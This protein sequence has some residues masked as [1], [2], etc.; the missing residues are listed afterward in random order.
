[1]VKKILFPLVVAVI[2]FSIGFSVVYAK[3]IPGVDRPFDPPDYY[4]PTAISYPDSKPSAFTLKDIAGSG[5]NVIDVTRKIKSALFGGDF[6]NLLNIFKGKLSIDELN[7]TPFDGS[8]LNRTLDN[9][10]NTNAKTA[11]L[12][13][14]IDINN[15]N[16][17][18]PNENYDADKTYDSDAQSSWLSNIYMTVTQAAKENLNDAE[19]QFSTLEDIVNNS[20]NAQGELQVQQVSSELKSLNSALMAR[21]NALLSNNVNMNAAV[22]K[23]QVDEELEGIRNTDNMGVYFADP[24]NEKQYEAAD[25]KRPEAPGFKD[26][27]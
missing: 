23:Q 16:F 24:Y 10:E 5:G 15:G 21:R 6:L 2:G 26:F 8:V 20:G 17:R 11:S 27:Q 3:I 18:T 14:S 19:N 22:Q 4:N 9:I 7:T 1:M 13:T 25:Y 12:S